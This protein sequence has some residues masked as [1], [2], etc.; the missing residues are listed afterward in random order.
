VSDAYHKLTLETH[1]LKW[2]DDLPFSLDSNDI[3]FQDDA[4]D[5]IEHVFL[6]PNLILERILEDTNLVIGEIGFGFGLNFLST[7]KSWVKNSNNGLLT[8][9]SIDHKV[10]TKTEIKRLFK[11][12]EILRDLED[13]FFESFDPIHKGINKFF[14]SNWNVELILYVGDVIDAISSLNGGF[15]M[16]AWY[17]DGF[18]PKANPM[19]WSNDVLDFIKTH[20][21]KN[22]TVSTFSA[23]GFIRRG[24]TERGFEVERKKGFKFKRHHIAGTYSQGDQR[25]AFK[26]IAVVGSGI[27]GCSTAY[28]LAKNGHDVE[29]FEINEEISSGA[30][31]NPLAALYPRF[32][33]NELPINTLN[34]SSFFYADRFFK[35]LNSEAYYRTGIAFLNHDKRT[36]QW[37]EKLKKLN[38]DDLFIFSDEKN[39]TGYENFNGVIFNH[40]GYLDPVKINECLIKH[41]NISVNRKYEFKS[42]DSTPSSVT[43]HFHDNK[44]LTF[45]YLVLAH[46]AG[47]INF[48][49]YL[50][51]S[52]GQLAGAKISDSIHMPINSNGYILP[53]KDGVNWIGSSYENQ[54]QNM[55]INKNKVQEM[56]E[57]QFD[58]FNLKNPQ[59]EPDSKAQIRVISKDKLPLTGQYKDN[60][61]VFLLGGLGSRGF[62][63]G[64]ILGDHIASLISDN[65]SP[66]EKIIADSLKPNRFK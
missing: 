22:S 20:S 5:E 40:G 49:N 8:F 29:L 64:P 28:H 23:A 30:S 65:V 54:F 7:C 19:M 57:F 17:L 39:V 53:L 61:N 21:N 12:F 51:L 63:Y 34:L 13:E 60:K 47:L 1:K 38:R 10:P 66:L 50:A 3:F 36:E 43:L 15:V 56:V 59:N 6:K 11:K 33:L 18:D 27:A 4:L 24:L 41:K 26:K 32:N 2:E 16:D 52:K 62:C 48:S 58:Q 35:S 55:N 37:I 31:G 44:E 45:D 25:Q 9:F 42:F 14:F 46:G